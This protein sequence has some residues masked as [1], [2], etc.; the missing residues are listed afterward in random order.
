MLLSQASF[1]YTGP[2]TFSPA[3]PVYLST[4]RPVPNFRNGPELAGRSG[5]DLRQGA[6]PG[7]HG[8]ESPS[9]RVGAAPRIDPIS[10]GQG[11][12]DIAVREPGGAAQSGAARIEVPRLHSS[13]GTPTDA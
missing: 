6:V 13:P 2:A 8:S 11:L 1:G 4:F 7:R 3:N 5:L 10:T 12:F 9:I